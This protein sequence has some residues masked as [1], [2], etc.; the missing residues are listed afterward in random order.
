MR[1]AYASPI[2]SPEMPCIWSNA[3]LLY[4][5]MW[6]SVGWSE[7]RCVVWTHSAPMRSE[8]LTVP[9]TTVSLATVSPV[10]SREGRKNV[11]YVPLP[12]LP[13]YKNKKKDKTK[14]LAM[15]PTSS[16][17][18]VTNA[19]HNVC[20]QQMRFSY[21]EAIYVGKLVKRYILYSYRI[22]FLVLRDLPNQ[23]LLAK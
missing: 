2:R 19:L 10:V 1:C 20:I 22:V 9:A 14:V 21:I 16:Q 11:T 13:I 8:G 23:S 6:M 17:S 15:Q 5:Q 7:W 4:L 18:W 3:V 12:S